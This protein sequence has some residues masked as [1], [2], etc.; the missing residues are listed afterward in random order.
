MIELA[1]RWQGAINR[2]AAVE[3]NRIGPKTQRPRCSDEQRRLVLAVTVA[4]GQDLGRHPRLITTKTQGYRD[5]PDILRNPALQGAQRIVRRRSSFEQ[6]A[7]LFPD[8]V[9]DGIP[10]TR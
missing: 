8:A 5:V 7:K 6:T 1:K 2:A 3:Q 4:G 10:V 9:F